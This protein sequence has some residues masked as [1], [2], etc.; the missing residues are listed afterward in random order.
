MEEKIV[1]LV[2]SVCTFSFSQCTPCDYTFR[3]VLWNDTETMEANKD[4]IWDY[5]PVGKRRYI[6]ANITV[7][8][9]VTKE[10]DDQRIYDI[11]K[12]TLLS[13]REFAAAH[14][15]ACPKVDGNC[16]GGYFSA[17]AQEVCKCC[18]DV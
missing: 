10:L 12:K 14:C 1:V 17:V 6:D 5:Q 18:S 3:S 16:R 8:S 2:R 7:I 9:N 4:Y 13:L 11:E 15:L